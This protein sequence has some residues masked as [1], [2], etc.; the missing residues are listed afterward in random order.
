MNEIITYLEQSISDA[1]LSKQEK[2]SL[3][4][5]IA[6]NAP[7]QDLLNFLRNKMYE[8]ANEKINDSNYRLILEWVKN[9]NI[10]FNAK[11]V[12]KSSAYFSPGESCRQAI[13]GQINSATKNLK[14]CVFTISDDLITQAI[15]AAHK[16]G[17]AIQ[18]LT[19]NDKLF[20]VG[21][22]IMQLS[23]SGITIKVDNTAN[24]MHHKFLIA[25]DRTVLSGSY[26][27][28]NSAA[29]FNQENIIVTSEGGIVKLFLKEFERLWGVMSSAKF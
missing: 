29:R 19:D 14:I 9:S 13:N 10:A 24:H 18:L 26:N 22:D 1:I 20:D 8:L 3:K 16:R 7:D 5:L 15:L 4:L 28:T 6:S 12:E 21:S 27:W 23:K 17:V 11:S 25:D 2:Q